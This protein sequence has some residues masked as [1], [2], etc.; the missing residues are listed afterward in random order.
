[1]TPTILN[2]MQQQLDSLTKR[3]EALENN[4]SSKNKQELIRGL[5]GPPGGVGAPGKDGK[6]GKDGLDGAP[7][8][9]GI[10]GKDATS[11]ADIA[12]INSI[13]DELKQQL[14]KPAVTDSLTLSDEL[15]RAAAVDL[16]IQPEIDAMNNSLDAEPILPVAAIEYVIDPVEL[17]ESAPRIYVSDEKVTDST[18]DSSPALANESAQSISSSPEESE[19]IAE[20]SQP[21]NF[22]E[23]A[24]S[25][26]E[27]EP[28]GE[29]GQPENSEES[30]SSSPESEPA[31][32]SAQPENSEES[33]S[34]SP[35]SEPAAESSQPESL[36]RVCKFSTRRARNSSR[37]RPASELGEL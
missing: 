13:L 8:K 3:V 21:A 23:S 27:S 2:R 31:A 18:D 20:S 26:P 35:E 11:S 16:L 29:S 33:A 19:P 32:E 10:D 24:N 34:S 1:M 15:Q 9:D 22:E 5:R 37:E 30:A 6:D 12:D 14:S 25:S 7:G 4:S 28:T 36:R 17:D